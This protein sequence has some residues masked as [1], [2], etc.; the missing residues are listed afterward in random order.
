MP[1]VRRTGHYT[2]IPLPKKYTLQ[3]NKEDWDDPT[4]PIRVR[5]TNINER[6]TEY[7]KIGLSPPFDPVVWMHRLAEYA[8]ITWNEDVATALLRNL[9][10]EDILARFDKWEKRVLGKKPTVEDFCNQTVFQNALGK[11]RQDARFLINLYAARAYHDQLNALREK[12]ELPVMFYPSAAQK[13][14]SRTWEWKGWVDG[15]DKIEAKE[16]AGG[17]AKREFQRSETKMIDEFA[18]RLRRS[19]RTAAEDIQVGVAAA[20]VR[21]NDQ[22]EL[23][24]SLSVRQSKGDRPP[25]PQR[26]KRVVKS[27]QILPESLGTSRTDG[28][29]ESLSSKPVERS[30]NRVTSTEASGGA[31]KKINAI[32]T[33]YSATEETDTNQKRH[34]RAPSG[35]FVKGGRGVTGVHKGKTSILAKAL[36]AAP[37]INPLLEQRPASGRAGSKRKLKDAAPDLD[38]VNWEK[39]TGAA[40]IKKTKHIQGEMEGPE[41]L[42]AEASDDPQD[43]RFPIKGPTIKSSGLSERKVPNKAAEADFTDSA[44]PT[45][46]DTPRRKKLILKNSAPR[47]TAP[48][49]SGR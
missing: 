10:N 45:S 47:P 30:R 26:Q 16:R 5:I 22:I 7:A 48:S 39:S 8:D 36:S 14:T 13:D 20:Q 25:K 41:M 31:S 49:D 6:W 9:T 3:F 18:S 42:E 44:T 27:S 28:L 19:A 33:A 46:D 2:M 1:A 43:K 38:D 4:Y 37:P 32:S 12:N 21:V 35:K 34:F 15:T 29:E 23:G 40:A 24:S 11:W 17:H